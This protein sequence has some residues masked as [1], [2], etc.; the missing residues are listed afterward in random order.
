MRLCPGALAF[1]LFAMG[2]ADDDETATSSPLHVPEGCNPIAADWDCLLPFPSDQYRSVD[3]SLPSGFRVALPEAARPVRDDGVAADLTTL[4]AA[5]GFSPGSQI[6]AFVPGGIDPTPLPFHDHIASSLQS[7]S[8]TLLVDAETGE[9]VPHFA[10][11]DPRA[12]SDDERGLVIRPVVRLRDAHRYVVALKGL[13]RPDGTPHVAPEGF[14]RIRAGATEGDPLLS[15][16]AAHYEKDVFP[17]LA[18]AGVPRGELLLAWDFTTRTEDNVVGDMLA[19]RGDVLEYLMKPPAFQVLGHTDQV[20]AHVHRRV[21]VSV[22]V[23]LYLDQSAP[24]SPLHRDAKGQVTSNG[25][26]DVPFSVIIPPSVA[27]RPPGAPPARLLQYGH[28]FFG[29]RAEAEGHPAEL[30]DEKG[31][32]VVTA[33]WVGMSEEDRIK[34]AD[35]MLADTSRMMQFTDRVH[36]AMA[37]FIVV[38]ALAQGALAAVPELQTSAGPAYDP[39]RLYFHGNSMGYILGASYVAL[40]PSIERAA[41]GVGGANFSFIMFRA[42]PFSFFLLLMGNILP[43]KLDQLKVSF[44]TQ[45][46]FDRI[47]PLTYAPRLLEHTFEGS[48][49]SRRVLLH[50]GMGDPSVP[51]LS[52]H[53][54][55]RTLGL[56]ELAPTPRDV[57]GIP[58]QAAPI[59][60]SAFVEFDFGIDPE[61]GVLAI[62][63]AASNP[64]HEGVRRLAASREQLS[65]FLEPEGKIESTCDGVCDPE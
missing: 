16:I 17:V 18:Q 2:C 51:P 53:L 59:D 27:N 29:S 50:A 45:L 24:L 13:R 21:D 28:G 22:K 65:R 14:R 56:P 47:D 46:S 20:N 37:N 31:F 34:V 64:V 15:P 25:E 33:D 48:P 36:Q 60:G 6:L 61:P 44:M 55:A 4:H 3:A 1:A 63:P 43:S 42:Q 12:D 54:H 39:S 57:Y 19:V 62:P 35:G 52:A 40:S 38:G 49:A 5:D 7:D 11:T 8:P 26:I 30:A 9:L 58:A 41:L 10:E 32:V 23:P